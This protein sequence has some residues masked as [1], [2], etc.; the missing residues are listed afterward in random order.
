MADYSV[1]KGWLEG[2]PDVHHHSMENAC[3]SALGLRTE[4]VWKIEL[5]ES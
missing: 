5:S 4:L 2:R 1:F 3:T